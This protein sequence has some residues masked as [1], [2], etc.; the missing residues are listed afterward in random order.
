VTLLVKETIEIRLTPASAEMENS[1]SVILGTNSKVEEGSEC[2]VM[3]HD[4]LTK[5]L[6]KL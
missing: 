4:Q 2:K 6:Y 5:M 3:V 1:H